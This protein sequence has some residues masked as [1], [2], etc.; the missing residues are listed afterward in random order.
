MRRLEDFKE[1][2]GDD[3][4]NDY[5]GSQHVPDT[6]NHSNGTPSLLRRLLANFLLQYVPMY[7]NDDPSYPSERSSQNKHHKREKGTQDR[8][9]YSETQHERSPWALDAVGCENKRR[10]GRREIT[11]KQTIS[12]EEEVEW[13]KEKDKVW[14]APQSTNLFHLNKAVETEL[15]PFSSSG[16]LAYTTNSLSVSANHALEHDEDL[17]CFNNSPHCSNATT[18]RRGNLTRTESE[19]SMSVV[20][21]EDIS[22]SDAADADDPGLVQDFEQPITI[23]YGPRACWRPRIL[24]YAMGE[25]I[26]IAEPD[27]E[28]KRLFRLSIPLTLTETVPA[29][30]DAIVVGLIANY[31][32]TDPVVAMVLAELLIQLTNLCTIGVI[33]AQYTMCS[34]ALEVNNFFL[35]GQY[36]Q[37]SAI[38]YSLVSLPAIVVWSCTM[39]ATV[40]W[41]GMSEYVAQQASEV[42]KVLVVYYFL[43]G[44]A[45][46]FLVVLDLKGFVTKTFNKIADFSEKLL[47]FI[48]IVVYVTCTDYPR[49]FT[50]AFIRFMMRITFLTFKLAVAIPC[51]WFQPFRRGMIGSL[52]LQNTTAVEN[53]LRASLRLSVGSVLQYSEFL[54]LI[55]WAAHMGPAEVATWSLLGA[56]IWKVLQALTDGVSVA[57]R[58]RVVYHLGMRDAHSAMRVSCKTLFLGGVLVPLL[59]SLVMI[60]LLAPRNILAA[61]FTRDETIQN[62]L[63]DPLLILAVGNIPLGFGRVARHLLEA[64]GRH[65]LSTS[66]TIA[67]SWFLTIVPLSV[68]FV[69]ELDWNVS[70]LLGAVL[71]GHI[72]TSAWIFA[73]LLFNTDWDRLV[74]PFSSILKDTSHE[75]KPDKKPV[76]QMRHVFDVDVF[77]DEDEDDDND[78][79]DDDCS[80]QDFQTA[81]SHKTGM[82]STINVSRSVASAL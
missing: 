71:L 38:I 79:D 63:H 14:A 43:E 25:L 24:L 9:D 13:R 50:I 40:L 78:D 41:F 47:V 11:T 6:T 65:R 34:R 35:M 82:N 31:I 74:S 16:K 20:N 36:V 80:E 81:C 68:V 70:G 29:L 48:M 72:M 18:V 7:P 2:H 10:I 69:Y 5:P 45:N 22:P 73:C 1:R 66:I 15:P 53:I 44:I 55:F 32:G 39:K 26:D 8:I 51:R 37:I 59:G 33:D 56:T 17:D 60:F 23:C 30:F 42:A 46:T 54:I 61:S 76:K 75:K 67:T 12:L 77:E 19:D 49:V 21:I 28:T 62:M 27:A 3:K 64:Q 4:L 58:V 57:G 52:A